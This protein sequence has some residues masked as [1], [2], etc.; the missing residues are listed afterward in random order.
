MNLQRKSVLAVFL[1]SVCFSTGGLFIK[2][3]PWSALAINGARNLIGSAVIGLYLL[4]TRH[5]VRFNRRV[6]IG[7]LSMIGVT[8]LFAVSNKL[9]T[10]ANAIVLQFTAPVFVILFMA[11]LYRQKPGRVDLVT[12]FLVLSGVVIFFVDGLRAGNLA[13][14]VT[15]ILSGMLF[16]ALLAFFHLLLRTNL[17]LTCI[18]LNSFSSGLTIFILF[19]LTGDRGV[20]TALRSVDLPKVAIPLIEKIPFVGEVLSGQ[21]ILTYLALIVVILV[22][23]LLYKTKLGTYIRAV[24]ENAKAIETAGYPAKR[25]RLYALL[26][27]GAIAG[28]GGAFMSMAYVSGFT[29]DMVSGR[30]FIALAAEAMGRGRPLLSTLAAFLFGF[31]DSLANN[32]QVVGLSSDLARMVPYVITIIALSLYAWRMVKPRR[33]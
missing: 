24:G 32:L 15:A 28:M 33:K 10:A 9:T 12:C 18:A 6:L 2:L 8:T 14:N 4:A 23:T 25:I 3:I 31:T 16:S 5:R 7:A 30:G 11:A 19:M 27:S 1:A 29:K 26:I 22:A 20:S 17:V 21:N 13:G